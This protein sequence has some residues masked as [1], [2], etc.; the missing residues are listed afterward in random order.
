[1][2]TK[3]DYLKAVDIVDRVKNLAIEKASTDQN[4]YYWNVSL[5][6]E[7]V[8]LTPI[9]WYGEYEYFKDRDYSL[10]IDYLLGRINEESS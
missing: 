2:I 1:M 7:F 4:H 8:Y 3:E 5:G 10:D 6:D 9:N